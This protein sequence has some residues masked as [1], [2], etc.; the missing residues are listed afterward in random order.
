MYFY[1]FFNRGI[2]SF[3]I[4]LT[5]F[6]KALLLHEQKYLV[7]MH[8]NPIVLPT[9]E[10]K[11]YQDY[12]HTEPENEYVACVHLFKDVLECRLSFQPNLLCAFKKYE[13]SR[14]CSEENN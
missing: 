12:D 3:E 13:K 2:Y 4:L 14:N 9:F 11:L 1:K 10:K 8:L 5:Y 7:Q 6:Y